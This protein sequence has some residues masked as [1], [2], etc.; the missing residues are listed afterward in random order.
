MFER[1]VERRKHLIEC[2]SKPYSIWY[3]TDE[4][5]LK[6]MVKKFGND[7][8]KIALYFDNH[9]QKQIQ[10]FMS[11]NMKEGLK[12]EAVIKEYE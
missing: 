8:E 9:T 7:P 10:S 4:K 1:Y 11:R 6:R 2:R 3:V 12:L 5:K